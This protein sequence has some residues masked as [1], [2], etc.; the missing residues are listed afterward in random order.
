[1]SANSLSISCQLPEA[2]TE[3]K[4]MNGFYRV[5]HVLL[6]NFLQNDNLPFVGNLNTQDVGKKVKQQD[7]LRGNE[8]L[9]PEGMLHKL[10]N[11]SI[12]RVYY[13]MSVHMMEGELTPATCSLSLYVSI[14]L[15]VSYAIIIIIIIIINKYKI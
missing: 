15:S 1:V 6:H 8:T 12:H 9:H 14:C 5:I 2:I 11:V 7:V 13:F 4:G 3:M 10:R